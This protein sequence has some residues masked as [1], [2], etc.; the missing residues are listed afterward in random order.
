MKLTYKY[1]VKAS[2][3]TLENIEECIIL[4]KNLYNGCITERVL[5]YDKF[6]H[7]KGTDKWQKILPSYYSQKKQLPELKLVDERYKK[8]PSNIF[9]DVTDRVNKTYSNFFR[10]AGFPQYKSR[11]FYNSFTLTYANGYF[12]DGVG[13][14]KLIKKQLEEN[15]NPVKPFLKI[16]NIGVLKILG[17]KKYKIQGIIKTI[18]V[19]KRHNN[20][21]VCFSTDNAPEY[22]NF[23]TGKS[24]GIDVGIANYLTLSD[25]T[26]IDNPDFGKKFEKRERVLNRSLARKK[27]FSGRWKLVAKQIAKEKSKLA[28]QRKL[29]QHELSKIIVQNYDVIVMEK[30]SIKNMSASAKGTIED[31]GKN[32]AQKSGLSKVILDG[33]F[34]RFRSMIE[35]KCKKYGKQLILV[36]PK[37]TSQICN[38]CGHK[39]SENR[40]SQEIF[41]CTLC[42]H[43]DHADVNAAKN[44]LDK[45][46]GLNNYVKTG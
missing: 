6:K 30:L 44:I 34:Y 4:C 2:K 26:K 15:Y 46:L 28:N 19:E 5:M 42:G 43:K 24:V 41:L 38:K 14:T 10:G 12:M 40:V 3:K 35:Y 13:S 11:K 37:F 22:N 25:G 27:R 16:S 1:K 45:G 21:W 23:M 39:D 18:T 9:Q 36:D 20:V 7:L 33:A 31:P 8:Y 32:V 17:Y 29:F